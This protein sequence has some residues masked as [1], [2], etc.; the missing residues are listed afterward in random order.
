VIAIPLGVDEQRF[1][2]RAS[3]DSRARLGVEGKCVVTTVARLYAYKGHETVLRAIR[4]LSEEEREKLVYLVAGTGPYDA[5]LRSLSQELGVGSCV[6]W[7]GF[8]DEEDLPGL[9]AATNLFALCTRE[10]PDERGV[11]GFGLALLEAQSCGVPVVGTATGGIPDAVRDGEGG[12]LI[13]QDDFVALSGILRSLVMDPDA[14]RREGERARRRVL[15]EA[16]W[17]HY[18]NRLVEVMRGVND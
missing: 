15:R 9:Y 16:T 4:E 11:E 7:L 10:S 8:V 14:F 13:A 3:S 5:S 2:S 17:E 1:R 6:R 18:G 12:W